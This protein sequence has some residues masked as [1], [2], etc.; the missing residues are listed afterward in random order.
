MREFLVVANESCGI[1]IVFDLT[2]FD[3]SQVFETTR[4]G[5]CISPA[6]G[7]RTILVWSYEKEAEMLY[8]PVASAVT[9][10]ATKAP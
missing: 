4:S 8:F 3:I 5:G 6:S 10:D 9:G 1:V 2:T 7:Q